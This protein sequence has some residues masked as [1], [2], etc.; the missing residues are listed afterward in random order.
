MKEGNKVPVKRFAFLGYVLC[1]DYG[2]I[3]NETR[4]ISYATETVK[5]PSLEPYPVQETVLDDA[6]DDFKPPVPPKP[7]SPI[8]PTSPYASSG[9]HSASF[10][11]VELNN[12][13]VSIDSNLA[14]IADALER[15]VV[16]LPTSLKK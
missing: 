12:R 7:T 10:I 5:L 13:L 11:P 8:S 4:P 1:P 6:L 2:D 3:V 16:V 14:R 9:S 15:L